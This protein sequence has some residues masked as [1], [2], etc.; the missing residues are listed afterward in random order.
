MRGA[1]AAMVV[2]VTVGAETAAVAM[3]VVMVEE[4]RAV[5]AIVGV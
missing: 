1:A 4:G 3:V 2:A 5:G